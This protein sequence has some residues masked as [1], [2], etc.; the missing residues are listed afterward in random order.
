MSN[1]L[2]VLG[3]LI[4]GD[5]LVQKR[6]AGN[7][8]ARDGNL[9]EAVSHFTQ[10]QNGTYLYMPT[11]SIPFLLNRQCVR[12]AMRLSDP[13]VGLSHPCGAQQHGLLSRMDS[14]NSWS[15]ALHTAHHALHTSHCNS[16]LGTCGRSIIADPLRLAAHA[17]PA[18][19]RCF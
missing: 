9:E 3:S 12:L 16:S 6:L 1:G 19:S 4:S 17:L 8:E 10:V 11:H 13:L 5:L 7:R 2:D 15:Y 14:C 18:L